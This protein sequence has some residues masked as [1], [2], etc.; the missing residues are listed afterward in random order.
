MVIESGSLAWAV[1][2][3]LLAGFLSFFSPCIIP[4]LPVY[5]SYISGVSVETIVGDEVAP[6]RRM[7]GS[8]VLFV[9]GFGVTF[10]AVG[11]AFQSVGRWTVTYR[12][13]ISVV[14]GLILIV[15][16][17]LVVANVQLSALHRTFNVGIPRGGMIVAPLVGAALAVTWLPCIGPVLG[18]IY[19]LGYQSASTERILVLLATYS[20]GLGVPF[21]LAAV[22]WNRVI[23]AVTWIKRHQRLVSVI[24]G[25]LLVVVGLLLAFG[26]WL[27]IAQKLQVLALD[28]GFT[29]F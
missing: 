22:A 9:A 16:G 20:L 23:G 29:G 26:F 28:W 17:V 3:A 18:A 5:L 8:A 11:V 21:I 2:I 4:L 12:D 27:T 19:S 6:R 25:S 14:S 13:T 7:A 1:P 10:T 15:L 24:T